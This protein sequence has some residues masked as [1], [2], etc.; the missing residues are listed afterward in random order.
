MAEEKRQHEHDDEWEEC[1]CL[2]CRHGRGEARIF[3][4]RVYPWAFAG[5][6]ILIAAALTLIGM[7]TGMPFLWRIV[8]AGVLGGLAIHASSE[9]IEL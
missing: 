6:V 7:T 5:Y 8:F 3:V 2:S 9:R 1:Q 4:T